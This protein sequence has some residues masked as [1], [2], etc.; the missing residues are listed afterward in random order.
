[1][2]HVKYFLES[3]FIMDLIL[4]LTASNS[5]EILSPIGHVQLFLTENQINP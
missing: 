3:I 2:E 5:M 1:M 4:S